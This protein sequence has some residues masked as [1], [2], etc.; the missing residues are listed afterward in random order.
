MKNSCLICNGSELR[1]IYKGGKYEI[2]QC[3]ICL[4]GTLRNY[5]SDKELKIFYQKSYFI[6][7]ELEIF[8]KDAEQK[9]KFV[10]KHLKNGAKILDFGCGTGEFLNIAKQNHMQVC[11]YDI[12][13]FAKKTVAKKYRIKVKSG[14]LQKALYAKG[15]F[16]AVVAFDVIEHIKNPKKVFE[17]F[18]YWLKPGGMIFLT[19]PNIRSWDAKILGK[20]WYGFKKLPEHI[21]YFSPVSIKLLLSEVGFN[22]CLIKN[23]GFVR[24]LNFLLSKLGINLHFYFLKKTNLFFPG[25]D[26]MIVA[27]R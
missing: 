27:K 11:G 19:T 23:W 4:F 16:D 1:V 8:S 25:I 15:S 17:F 21:H 13:D 3:Q 7:R 2:I 6:E 12:S 26:M 5:P 20:H 22:N 9:F 14:P 10:K 18:S 24:P